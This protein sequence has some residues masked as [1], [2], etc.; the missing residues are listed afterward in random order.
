MYETAKEIMLSKFMF[1]VCYIC[2]MLP[3]NNNDE[4]IKTAVMFGNRPPLDDITEP[5]AWLSALRSC[6]IQCWH[7]SPDERPSFDGR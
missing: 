2:W 6:I 5:A 7:E 1:C 4:Q 3:A